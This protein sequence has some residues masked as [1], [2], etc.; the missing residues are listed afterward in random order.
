M[1]T[2][3]RIFITAILLVPFYAQAESEKPTA[4]TRQDRVGNV[5][6]VFNEEVS[7]KVAPAGHTAANAPCTLLEDTG[8]VVYNEGAIRYN[9]TTKGLEYCNGANWVSPQAPANTLAVTR[10][11]YNKPAQAVAV[12]QGTFTNDGYIAGLVACNGGGLNQRLR[13]HL[14]LFDA[15]SGQ[16]KAAAGATAQDVSAGGYEIDNSPFF[17][18]VPAKVPW[19]VYISSNYSQKGDNT[20]NC[21]LDVTKFGS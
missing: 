16:W 9:K 8:G 11:H 2:E 4:A 15:A 10:Y 6:Y 14:L 19:Q 18:V 3:L 21:S 13:A 5:E 17:S 1:Q 20:A 7:I 12:L